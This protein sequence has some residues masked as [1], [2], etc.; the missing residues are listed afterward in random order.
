MLL[1]LILFHRKSNIYDLDQTKRQKKNEFKQLTTTNTITESKFIWRS[2][3]FAVVLTIS[4]NDHVEIRFCFYRH[5]PFHSNDN[6]LTDWS[7]TKQIY[8]MQIIIKWRFFQAG[9]KA[10]KKKKEQITE[11]I[12]VDWCEIKGPISPLRMSLLTVLSSKDLSAPCA[13]K[14]FI[15]KDIK[16]NWIDKLN[17]I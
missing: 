16:N 13:L 12:L 10:K 15:W 8:F 11:D 2:R 7:N 6:S 4:S 9:I 14:N 1:S 5:F 17:D 3:K